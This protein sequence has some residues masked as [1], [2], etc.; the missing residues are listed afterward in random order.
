MDHK[1]WPMMCTLL[2]NN[3]SNRIT[4]RKATIWKG[5]KAPVFWKRKW[6][7]YHSKKEMISKVIELKSQCTL[8]PKFIWI[9]TILSSFLIAYKLKKE[10]Q[11]SISCQA[12]SYQWLPCGLRHCHISSFLYIFKVILNLPYRAHSYR[13]AINFFSN[14][15][16]INFTTLTCTMTGKIHTFWKV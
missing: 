14:K 15:N 16:V 10:T 3:L 11:I 4:I 9:D 6:N 2:Y 8:L 7:L 1:N 13:F 12:F 5:N